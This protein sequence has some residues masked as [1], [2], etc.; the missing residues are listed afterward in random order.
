M[1]KK[2]NSQQEQAKRVSDIMLGKKRQ[3]TTQ[4]FRKLIKIEINSYSNK[5]NGSGNTFYRIEINKMYNFQP[6]GP[7]EETKAN[8]FGDIEQFKGKEEVKLTSSKHRFDHII[9]K[10]KFNDFHQLALDLKLG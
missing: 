2:Q 5:N 7:A 8:A 1:D 6:Q 3:E 9:V 10:K 4:E